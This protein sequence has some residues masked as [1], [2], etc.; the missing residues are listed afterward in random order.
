MQRP[1]IAV[2]I[3]SAFLTL[4]AQAADLIQ[5]Y[6]QALA[7]DATYA[8]ARSSLTAGQE[9]ITQGRS[10]LLPNIAASGSNTRNSGDVSQFL[11]GSY[12]PKAD[13]D[14]HS[15]SYTVQLSQPL[16]NWGNWQTYQQSKLAQATAEATFAQAQQDLITRVAQAYFDVLT[17]QDNLTSTQA[18]K[19]ATTEQL[20]SAKRNFEVGTQ[21]ITDTHEAQAA[22]DLVVAQEFAAINDL[23]NKRTALQVIIGQAPGELAP[24]RTGVTISA[25]SPAAV[26][27]WVSSAENQNYAV[28]A[29]K[30]NVEIAKREIE[31][32]RAGHMPTA[33]LIASTTH[34]TTTG[35]QRTNNN[36]I[37]VSWNVP[38]FSGFAVTSKVRETIALEDK[39]RN[40]LEATKRAASQNARS[41]YLGMN[42]GLAQVKA[43]EAAEVSSKSSLDSN[44]LGYQVG[45][46]INI[47]V[48]NAQKLLY[49]TQK[50]LAKA[51]YDTIMNGLRLKS[52]AG[53]LKED[54]LA[55][56]NALLA[57]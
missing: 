14:S 19:V 18:Q 2:L 6:Q 36:A 49:S 52:A 1:L 43:L 28:V 34:Q 33:N 39:A 35:Q 11:G 41:A 17:A 37:G 9:R 22:Y 27:P 5:V 23:D 42:S 24:L 47:D 48:L 32:N 31:R 46:R 50:D 56:I 20:A 38:I 10:G 51:R 45:V 44:K 7:N 40:D 53:S 26:E 54:D 12:T 29:A 25:P 30:L 8:G 3:T 55:P 15:N 13:V 21:T 4:N 57:H 16:F